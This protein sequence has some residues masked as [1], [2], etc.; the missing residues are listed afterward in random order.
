MSI[1]TQCNCLEECTVMI[2]YGY[3][4]PERYD[5]VSEYACT[6]CKQRVGRWSGKILTGDDYENRF[7]Y[8]K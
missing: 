6:E 7:G 2:E 4:H 8:A 3:T 5:G 1:K